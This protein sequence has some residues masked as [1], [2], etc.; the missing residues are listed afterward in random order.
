MT[1][2]MKDMEALREQFRLLGQTLEEQPI[3][4]DKW[5]A[6]NVSGHVSGLR[7]A[8]RIDRNQAI[9]GALLPVAALLIIPVAGWLTQLMKGEPLMGLAEMTGLIAPEVRWW[10]AAFVGVLIFFAAFKLW[11]YMAEKRAI[12]KLEGLIQGM[13]TPAEIAAF[14]KTVYDVSHSRALLTG[15]MLTQVLWGSF[16]LAFIAVIGGASTG[17]MIFVA[18]C[19][20]LGIVLE[21]MR[22]RDGRRS[23]LDDRL[24]VR[25]KGQGVDHHLKAI[26]EA[27]KEL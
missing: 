23:M 9:Y 15:R 19:F 1:E 22:N 13:G 3:V 8:L 14:A 27:Y 2:E 12:E 16:I 20:L 18:A 17:L 5:V 25:K 26:I 10:V 11:A 24:L 6:A 21:P 4:T 7:Q